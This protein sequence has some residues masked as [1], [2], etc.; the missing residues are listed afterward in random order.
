MVFASAYSEAARAS[1]STT[2]FFKLGLLQMP[3]QTIG[4]I[5]IP[6][7]LNTGHCLS[8]F[9][10]APDVRVNRGVFPEK[11]DC[12]TV[13]RTPASLRQLHFLEESPHIG[14]SG[15]EKL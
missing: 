8:L 3:S 4:S 15:F 10:F 13:H 5:L 12:R 11:F 14:D 9:G 2:R 6:L 1:P 7:L